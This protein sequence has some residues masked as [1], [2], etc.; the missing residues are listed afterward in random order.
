M[1][2]LNANNPVKVSGG[3]FGGFLQRNF[4]G[5][6]SAKVSFNHGNISGN[7]AS[8][9]DAQFRARNLSF[10]TPLDELA[11]IGSFNFLNYIPEAGRNRFTPFIYAGAART[12]YTPTATYEGQIYDLRSYE[13]EGHSYP[14]AT[15]SIVYGVG[16][17]YNIMGKFTISADFGYRNTNTDYLDD[18]S[19]KY[20][21]PSQYISPMSQILGDRSGE[22]TG[23]Y[24]GTP[25]SQRGD[26]NPH[27]TYFFTQVSISYTFVTQK[28][29]FER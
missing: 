1:G 11:L 28:C 26:M 22:N 7:D 8:S 13:T 4:D 3:S 18:V 23:V 2:D 19:G 27:D 16:V 29:Y 15:Y 5:Y 14:T 25:G 17:K 10:S 12:N 6:W 9:S 21:A 24:I 20:L